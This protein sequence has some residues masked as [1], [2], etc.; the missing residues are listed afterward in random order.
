MKERV[1]IRLADQARELIVG[2]EVR[3]S[4]TRERWRVE[5][6]LVSPAVVTN[7]AATIDD[8]RA[9]RLRRRS[10]KRSR[11]CI[12]RSLVILREATNSPRR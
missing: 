10:R 6:R 5:A 9:L 3:G 11:T 7:C 4:Q 1:E 2:A 8:Q 12:D